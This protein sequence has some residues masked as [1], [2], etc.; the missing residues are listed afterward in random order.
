MGIFVQ[1]SKAGIGFGGMIKIHWHCWHDIKIIK[2]IPILSR[3]KAK[4]PEYL[5]YGKGGG[6][7]PGN[8]GMK[9]TVEQECCICHKIR[10]KTKYL[11]RTEIE[12][13][14]DKMRRRDEKID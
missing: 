6:Y 1:M 11:T 12:R 8:W 4:V 5:R 9:V 13:L 14:T 3:C 2:Y 10:S 7:S